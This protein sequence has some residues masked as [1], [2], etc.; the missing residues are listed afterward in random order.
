MEN[1]HMKIE[2]VDSD[3]HFCIICIQETKKLSRENEYHRLCPVK[4]FLVFIAFR[5]ETPKL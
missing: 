3:N 2:I 4:L 5:N 1:C